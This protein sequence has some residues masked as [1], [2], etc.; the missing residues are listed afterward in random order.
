MKHR[1]LL[2]CVILLLVPLALAGAE[3]DLRPQW[4]ATIPLAN[5]H[6]GW[7]HHFFD[8][9]VEKYLLESDDELTKFPGMDHI[10]LRLAWSYLEPVEGRFNWSVVDGPI[11]KWT[12]RGLGVAFRISCKETGTN[13]IE[14]QFATPRWVR[15]AGAR[16]GFYRRGKVEGPDAP[17]EP[18]YDDAVFLAKLEKFLAAFAARYDGQPWLRYVDIGSLGDWGE[19]HTSSGSKLKY[20]YAALERHVDLHLKCFKKTPLVISDDYVTSLASPE[21]RR[22]LHAKL[23]A[24]GVSYRDDSPLVDWFITAY[25]KT[26]TVRS[27]ELFADAWP[28]TP[29]VFELEHYGSVKRMGNWLAQPGSSLAKFGAGRTGADYFRGALELLHATYIGY[30]GYAREWLADNPALTGELLNRCGYWFFPHTVTLPETLVA[31]QTNSITVRW[32]NRGVARA[33]HPYELVVKLEGAETCAC[34]VPAGNTRWLPA[35]ADK[36]WSETYALAL[37]AQLKS[38]DY[39]LKLKLRSREAA[40]DVLL[41]LKAGLL[42][43]DGFYTIGRVRVGA[44]P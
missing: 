19:G 1:T 32:Q 3:L 6:K 39:A 42:D 16:G 44:R 8:N 14:Q 31:G 35:A 2:A 23:L 29:T 7:Y 36:L 38:G 4:D 33:Y 24:A 41:P 22:R 27:P 40:R 9:T 25:S 18:V 10:Y 43:K 13:R 20:G 17:W 21:D 26:F 12:A 15:D 37:P 11:A 28:Q 5:P 34:E 30:H